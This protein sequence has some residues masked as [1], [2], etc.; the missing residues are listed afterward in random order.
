MYQDC[1]VTHAKIRF[2]TNTTTNEHIKYLYIPKYENRIPS[3]HR[4]V[5]EKPK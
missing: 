5:G 4:R 3:I 2:V 1:D